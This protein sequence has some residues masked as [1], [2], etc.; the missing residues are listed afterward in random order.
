[1]F[2]LGSK[3]RGQVQLGQ[4]QCGNFSLYPVFSG[5]REKDSICDSALV[6]F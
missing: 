1:M 4:C 2:V 5:E 3:E 6:G